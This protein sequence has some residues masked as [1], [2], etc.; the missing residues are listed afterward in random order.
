MNYLPISCHCD[1]SCK[2]TIDSEV[3]LKFVINSKLKFFQCFGC[4]MLP[5]KLFY[6]DIHFNLISGL[7]L[8][9]LTD[10]WVRIITEKCFNVNTIISMQMLL[11][12]FNTFLPFSFSLSLFKLLSGI[13]FFHLESPKYFSSC[14]SSF[15]LTFSCWLNS[16]TFVVPYW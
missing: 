1:I 4:L 2:T 12:W 8:I 15:C 13:N 5:L 9:A 6:F 14:S 16:L 7:S 10:F 3:N 11:T